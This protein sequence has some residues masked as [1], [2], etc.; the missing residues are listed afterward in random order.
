M[1]VVMAFSKTFWHEFIFPAIFHFWI[2]G[3]VY[4][5]ICVHFLF[6]LIYILVLKELLDLEIFILGMYV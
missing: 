4:H 2:I 3:K 5:N 6:G 1:N